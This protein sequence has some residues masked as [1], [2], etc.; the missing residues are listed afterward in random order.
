MTQDLWLDILDNMEPDLIERAVQTEQRLTRTK[1]RPWLKWASAAA[2][3]LLCVGT[4]FAVAPWEN[5]PAPVGEGVTIPMAEVYLA[6]PKDGAFDMAGLFIYN[7]K[8]YRQFDWVQ[9]TKLA[10]RYVCTVTGTIDEWTPQDGYVELAGTISGDMHA[11]KGYDPSYLLCEVF[12]DEIIL[13]LNNS[14]LTLYNGED[15]YGDVFHLRGNVKRVTCK[16]QVAYS[17]SVDKEGEFGKEHRQLLSRLIDALYEAPFLYS[18]DAPLESKENWINV[19]LLYRMEFELDNGVTLP[20]RLY[21]DG[22]V[23]GA[24]IGNVCVKLDE[25]LYEELI[26]VLTELCGAP[27]YL[28]SGDALACTGE[29]IL[30]DFMELPGNIYGATAQFN[31]VN[32]EWTAPVPLDEEGI[33][34]IYRLIE[35]MRDIPAVHLDEMLAHEGWERTQDGPYYW[36]SIS[37]EYVD[38]ASLT[39]HEGGWV[40]VGVYPLT[41]RVESDTFHELWTLCETLTDAARP[42][43]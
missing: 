24:G 17:E 7:G 30:V 5:E 15:W 4:L 2:C 26:S 21:R 10:G 31:I 12:D 19:N 38:S 11:V 18:E 3:L 43:E 27:W 13:Y 40:S 29:D 22:Y 6:T 28:E 33:A 23:T 32:R 34:L 35:E 41:F 39:L 1:R 42:S 36:V 20:L 8:V 37:A 16:T 25:A 9:N 14:G